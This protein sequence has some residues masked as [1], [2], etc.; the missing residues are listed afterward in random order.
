MAARTWGARLPYSHAGNS[1]WA[2]AP[3]DAFKIYRDVGGVDGL[4]LAVNV[5]DEVAE[6]TM[7]NLVRRVQCGGRDGG[8]EIAQR[9][10]ARARLQWHRTSARQL[11]PSHARLTTRIHRLPCPGR[12]QRDVGRR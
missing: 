3:G 5:F 10:L 4:L 2:P 8:S 1:H 12:E 9:S 6:K 7:W 11:L